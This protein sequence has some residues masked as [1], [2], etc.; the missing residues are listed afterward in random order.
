[1]GRLLVDLGYVCG[2]ENIIVLDDVSNGK[3]VNIR[4]VCAKAVFESFRCKTKR[5]KSR[6]IIHSDCCS[7]EIIHKGQPR[8]H[9]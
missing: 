2:S 4:M 7:L 3:I 9:K 1:V 8:L 6:M 5:S